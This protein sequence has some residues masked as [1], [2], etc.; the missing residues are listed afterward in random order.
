MVHRVEFFRE[1]RKMVVLQSLKV[2]HL[3]NICNGF[4]ESPNLRNWMCELCIY[5]FLQIWS[6]ILKGSL[7]TDGIEGIG[8]IN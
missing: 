4:Y 6:H 1:D 2:S 8:S 3:S 5:M 7:T